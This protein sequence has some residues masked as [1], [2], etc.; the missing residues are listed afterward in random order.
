LP[1]LAK[2][3]IA[4]W[5]KFCPSYEII[6]WDEN[7]YDIAKNLYMK[8]AYEAKKWGFVPDYARLDIIYNHGGI[9]LDTDVEIVKPFDDL[10]QD[11]MFCGFETSSNVAFGLGFGA[12]KG[13]HILK[14]MMEQY[15]KLNFINQDGSLNLIASPA[16]Q[17]DVLKKYKLELN[18]KY[19]NINGIAVYPNEY[20]CPK[21][22]ETDELVITNNTHSIHHYISSW[23]PS[24]EKRKIQ[25]LA[26]Y[27]IKFPKYWKFFLSVAHPII[28][29]GLYSEGKKRKSQVK[30]WH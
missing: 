3:C 26:K 28:S 11:E 8:Q 6:R 4:S 17:T 14:N 13:H 19:Q 27:K 21:S 2:K 20:F 5:S 24:K 15:E 10:L 1:K 12:V 18:N 30:K 22:F 29:L 16:Y 23:M 25:A 7:N 9:Y